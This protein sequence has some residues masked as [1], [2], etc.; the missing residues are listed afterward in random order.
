MEL[1]VTHK[2]KS[3]MQAG[4]KIFT[5][6][7]GPG[8]DPQKTVKALKDFGYDVVIVELEHALLNDETVYSYILA[9]KELGFPVWLRPEENF[10]NYRR[11]LDSGINGLLLGQLQT[12]EQAVY[13]VNQSYFPTIGHRGTAIGMDPY[14][15]DFQ[16]FQDVPYLDLIEYINNNT[17]VFPMVES[18]ASITNLSQI[19][20][21]DGITGTLVGT[22]DLMVD[23]AYAVGDAD[24]KALWAERLRTDFMAEKLR[25]VL[26]ICR[27]T[28]KVAGIGGLPIEDT[29]EWAKEGYQLLLLGYTKDGNVDNLQPIIEKTKALIG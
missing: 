24:R 18:L 21:L 29:A 23:V 20:R 25:K 26:K 9:G 11:Y 12:L 2:L 8:N 16:N 19:L 22:N 4:E 1:N 15:V 6:M 14:L 13:A 28:G 27:D 7:T 3:K 5:A 17:V 10:A